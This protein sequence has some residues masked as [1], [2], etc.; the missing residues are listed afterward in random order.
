MRADVLGDRVDYIWR[1]CWP[2]HA[3]ESSMF[4][5]SMLFTETAPLTRTQLSLSRPTL[6]P[7]TYPTSHTTSRKNYRKYFAQLFGGMLEIRICGTVFANTQI[8]RL[9]EFAPDAHLVRHYVTV[10]WALLLE[11]WKGVIHAHVLVS[12]TQPISDKGR[13]NVLRL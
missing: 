8:Q 1:W 6:N 5:F 9:K 7:K 2:R 12:P 10:T 11:M 4:Q 13:L 3:G